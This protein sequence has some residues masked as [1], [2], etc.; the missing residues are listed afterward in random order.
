MPNYGNLSL[1][2]MDIQ[3]LIERQDE[4]E[5]EI[6]DLRDSMELLGEKNAKTEKRV[7]ELEAEVQYIR[8]SLN[9]IQGSVNLIQRGMLTVQENVGEL[10]S[11]QDIAM[12]AQD[13]FIDSQTE[14]IGQLW[15]AFFALLGLITAAGAAAIALLK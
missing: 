15:K 2:E 8:K 5:R 13:K 7:S 12:K 4:L 14:F 11:K 6:K 9:D 1:K 10:N 3:K